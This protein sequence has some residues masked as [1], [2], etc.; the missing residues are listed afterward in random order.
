MGA[1]MVIRP[2]GTV[3]LSTVF[4]CGETLEPSAILTGTGL[5]VTHVSIRT[6]ETSRHPRE[7]P[8]TVHRA[9]CYPA[10]GRGRRVGGSLE[11]RYI[12]GAPALDQ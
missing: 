10:T 9:F 6:S 4:Q 5:I 11:L 7:G 3:Y 2:L 8:S 12:L 1:R